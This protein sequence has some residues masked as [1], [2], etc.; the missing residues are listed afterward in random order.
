MS[1]MF[2]QMF[3][4]KCGTNALTV[5][6]KVDVLCKLRDLSLR[7]PYWLLKEDEE[8]AI[9]SLLHKFCQV[10]HLECKDCRAFKRGKCAQ[11]L[12]LTDMFSELVPSHLCQNHT[13][14]S[15]LTGTLLYTMHM[16]IFKEI[17]E[18]AEKGELTP[19]QIKQI[20]AF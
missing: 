17:K 12:T 10:P 20:G 2:Y 9:T 3:W 8:I 6:Q 14:L 11:K 16:E 15:S 5:E 13:H 7:M 4:E 18:L 19:E 1:E